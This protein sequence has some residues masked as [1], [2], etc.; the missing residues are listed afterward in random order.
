MKFS[1]ERNITVPMSLLLGVLPIVAE[2]QEET[3]VKNILFI[4]VDDL[5][6]EMGCYGHPLVKS[7]N[8]DR[9]ADEGVRFSRSYCN[10]PVSGA[11]RASVLTGLRPTWKTFAQWNSRVDKDAPNALT[12]PQYFQDLGYT[13]LSN[14]KIY[15]HDDEVAK[16]YWDSVMLPSHLSPMG[17]SSPENLALMKTNAQKKS[18]RGYFYEVSEAEESTFLDHR[19]ASKTISDLQD[20]KKSEKPFFLALGFLKP[21]LPFIAPKRFWELYDENDIVLPDNFRLKEG[22]NIPHAALTGWSELRSY[23]GIPNKGSLDSL[24]AQKMIHGYYASLSFVDSQIGRVL[25]ELK[26][27]G[28]DKNTA[29]VLIGDHGWNLGEHAI[30]CKHCVMNTSLHTPMIISTPGGLKKHVS[31]EVVEFVDLF[32][33]FCE[34]TG[35]EIPSQLEG[36]S[37]LPLLQHKKAKHKGYAVSRWNNGF[38]YINERYHYTEWYDKKGKVSRQMLFDHKKDAAENYNLVNTTKKY[39]KVAEKLSKELEKKRGERF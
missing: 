6:P 15:H 27:L 12:I 5:R 4:M 19:L 34:L 17:Y 24:T 16:K 18:K 25:D 31:D 23:S 13:T 7:P 26:R 29:V 21:H 20:F 2:A 3:K 33:S 30:W 28:L 9:L 22:H 11:S 14:G 8:I 38:T 32:P 1:Q 10:I 36:K 37:L 39:A 35:E